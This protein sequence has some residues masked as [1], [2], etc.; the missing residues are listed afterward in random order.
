MTPGRTKA[1]PSAQRRSREREQRRDCIL[2]AAEHV[3][4]QRGFAQTTMDQV[5]EQAELS[6]GTLYLYFKNKDDLHVALSTC[7][8][9]EV[10]QRFTEVLAG[11]R[12]GIELVERAMQ[13]YG[14]VVRANPENFRTSVIWMVSGQAADTRTPEFVAHRAKIKRLVA[15]MVEAIGRG[16]RDG[17]IRRDLDPTQTAFRLWAAMVGALQIQIN[18]L[19]MVRRFPAPVDLDAFFAGLLDLLCEGLRPRPRRSEAAG[20]RI[21]RKRSSR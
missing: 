19:E 20:R 12:S 3:F 13:A 17:S 16:Q 18:R 9:D 21:S 4:H 6:K 14:E 11:D 2:R 5:A 1:S 15:A 10:L 7:M 8:V